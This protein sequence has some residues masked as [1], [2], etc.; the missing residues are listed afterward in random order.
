MFCLYS[1]GLTC[2]ATDFVDV[3]FLQNVKD[4]LSEQGLFVINL[5]SRSSAMKDMVVSRMKAVRIEN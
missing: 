5:V 4:T 1:S 2:P 3:S